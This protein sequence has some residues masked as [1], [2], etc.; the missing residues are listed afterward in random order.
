MSHLATLQRARRELKVGVA[1]FDLLRLFG[2]I[3]KHCV[4]GME[5]L[6]EDHSVYAPEDEILYMHKVMTDC[7]QR[8]EEN[9]FPTFCFA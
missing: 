7:Q 6:K 3:F 8:P 9:S 1:G 4:W 5:T 2:M